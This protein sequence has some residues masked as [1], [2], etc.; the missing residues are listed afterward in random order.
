MFFI[1]ITIWHL[2][3]GRRHPVLHTGWAKA[4]V[5]TISKFNADVCAQVI[6]IY[7]DFKEETNQKIE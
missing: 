2:S 4:L 5:N 7:N 3:M 6:I 1:F